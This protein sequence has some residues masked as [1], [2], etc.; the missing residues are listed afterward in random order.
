M[1]FHHHTA[2]NFIYSSTQFFYKH[3]W[4]MKSLFLAELFHNLWSIILLFSHFVCSATGWVLSIW[5]IQQ[6]TAVQWPF[7]FGARNILSSIHHAYNILLS[8][9]WEQ[10]KFYAS[11]WC[12]SHADHVFN[13]QWL[14]RMQAT[15]VNNPK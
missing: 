12:S 1:N 3:N 7:F 8:Q 6:G 15:R 11:F 2:V 10:L 5:M 14:Y 4:Q 9:N 13:N